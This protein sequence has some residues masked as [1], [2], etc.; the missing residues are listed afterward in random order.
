MKKII[1]I[2]LA[3]I[4]LMLA[5]AG[6]SD[7]KDNKPENE[8][9]ANSAV[10]NSAEEFSFPDGITIF[11]ADN[12]KYAF[13][14]KATH[15]DGTEKTYGIRTDKETIGEAL[16]EAGLLGGRE[17]STGY[18]VYTIDGVKHDHN[19]EGFYWVLYIN[20]ELAEVDVMKTAIED[21]ATYEFICERYMK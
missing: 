5:F 15:K 3:A 10:E 17:E 7:K 12:S 8:T 19:T 14:F 18:V 1:A 9:T 6:C 16:V 4:T 21:G 11:G 2:L 13:L 20:G